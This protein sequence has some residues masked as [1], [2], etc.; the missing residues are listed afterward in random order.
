M[1]LN[2]GSQKKLHAS[3]SFL[4]LDSSGVITIGRRASAPPFLMRYANFPSS[5]MKHLESLSRFQKDWNTTFED[6]DSGC[7]ELF[8]TKQS[9]TFIVSLSLTKVLAHLL[10]ASFSISIA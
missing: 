2:E 10:V 3:T 9:L 5:F 6:Q 1:Q 4:F 7:L 8:A